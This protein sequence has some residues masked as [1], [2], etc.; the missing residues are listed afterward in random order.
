MKALLIASTAAAS[1]F[2]ASCGEEAE[3]AEEGI[4]AEGVGMGEGI[5]EAGVGAVEQVGVAT[6]DTDNDGLFN[7]TEYTA[8]RDRGLTEWDTDADNQL[9]Q[10]EFEA[11]WT[12][13]GFTNAGGVFTDW[14]DNND[15]FLSNDEWF[16]DEEWGE[17]DAD[18]SGVLETGEWG[19]Y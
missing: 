2:L 12:Q 16:D 5:G 1:L 8:W 14:D 15:G 18:T 13:A 10:Q 3:V 4:V 7:E 17:W 9:T 19:Y 11:G 6:W